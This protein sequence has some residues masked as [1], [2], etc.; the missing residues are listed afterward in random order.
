MGSVRPDWLEALPEL[1]RQGRVCLWWHSDLAQSGTTKNEVARL[2]EA[3]HAVERG[4]LWAILPT[5]A[6]LTAVL[7]T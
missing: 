7:Q 4:H 5:S 2:E 3:I 6:N 1:G